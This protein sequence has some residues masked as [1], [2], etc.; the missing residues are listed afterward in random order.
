M[1]NA[2]GTINLRNISNLTINNASACNRF[3]VDKEHIHHTENHTSTAT[4]PDQNPECGFYDRL[5]T[6]NKHL[7]Y[8][9][10][11]NAFGTKVCT[12]SIHDTTT[13]HPHAETCPASQQPSDMPEPTKPTNSEQPVQVQQ[14]LKQIIYET[15]TEPIINS[16]FMEYINIQR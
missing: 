1:T 11:Q 4:N 5:I 6:E 14:W 15:E 8:K 13:M 7:Q 10:M 12:P 9:L 3:K 16:E 2:N